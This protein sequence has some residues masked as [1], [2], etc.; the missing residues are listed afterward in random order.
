MFDITKVLHDKRSVIPIKNMGDDLCLGRVLV[1]AKAMVDND[2][3]KDYIKRSD[4]PR[5]GYKAQ[6]LYLDARVQMSSGH[7]SYE[8]FRT[9]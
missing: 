4:R 5:Q 8:S 3:H 7:P 1:V 2:V 6:N 9:F